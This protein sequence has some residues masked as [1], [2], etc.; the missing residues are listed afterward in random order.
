MIDYYLC[1]SQAN[2][3]ESGL[4]W[5]MPVSA[6]HIWQDTSFEIHKMTQISTI[7]IK[8]STLCESPQQYLE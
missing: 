5:E 4:A 3:A 7:F 2:Y 1:R 6:L 8:E